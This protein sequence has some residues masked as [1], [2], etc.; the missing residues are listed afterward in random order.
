MSV[1]PRA[2]NRSL[3]PRAANRIAALGSAMLRS[4]VGRRACERP[5]Q[6]R[7]LLVLHELLLGDTLMLA[8]LLAALRLRY[9]AAALYVAAHPAYAPLFAGGP[10][11]AIA[12]PYTERRPGALGNLEPARGADIAFLPGENRYAVTARALGA[13]WVVGLEGGSAGWRDNLV[14]ELVPLPRKPRNLAEI[15]ASLAGTEPP[16]YRSGDWPA[17]PFKEFDRPTK[18]Y[19]VLHVGASTPL[20]QWPAASWRALAEALTVGGYEVAWSAG[21]GEQTIVQA[22]DPE[23]RY[24]SHAGK[25]D[26]AQL[27]HLVADCALLVTLDTGIAHLAKLTGTRTL[28]L[29]GPGSAT[30]VGR[31][32][33][34][35]TAPFRELTIEDFPCRDQRI[36][37]KREIEWVRRCGRRQNECPKPRCMEA[38]DAERVIQ[39]V[40]GRKTGQR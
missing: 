33:F 23:A 9:P 40:L 18:P 39:A 21:S 17:P 27:W 24:R 5:E 14:D 35:R 30:L 3:S 8:A 20:K 10:Y 38:I 7:K 28:C 11:G 32:S 31:G 16:P 22:V 29:Y 19:A 2:A 12:L 36:L 1:S 4:V 25:L 26:S 13:R 37:F 6:P 15:F 34:W